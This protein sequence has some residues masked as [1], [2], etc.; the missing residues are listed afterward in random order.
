MAAMD[1]GGVSVLLVEDDPLLAEV[2]LAQLRRAG[3]AAEHAA[4]AASAAAMG[5]AKAYD[6]VL[7]DLQLPDGTGADV[8]R[9]L[10]AAP[11]GSRDSLVVALT[12][13]AD[14]DVVAEVRAQGIDHILSKPLSPDR[15]AAILRGREDAP[16]AAA[17]P[18]RDPNPKEAVP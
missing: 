13:Y 5:V 1:G 10:R 3:F 12:A 6:L 17:D 14:E 2:T 9:A 11:G 16:R 8:A 4:T 15:I 18:D 7:L